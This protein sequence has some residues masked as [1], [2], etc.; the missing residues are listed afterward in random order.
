VSDP[1]MLKR[2]VEAALHSQ[3]LLDDPAHRYA[4]SEKSDAQADASGPNPPATRC[5]AKAPVPK[6]TTPI[7]LGTATFHG[8]PAVIVYTRDGVR[9]LVYVLASTDCRLLTSQFIGG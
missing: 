8:A 7:Y 9:V 2:R 3:A 5:I 4:A 1:A 6:G